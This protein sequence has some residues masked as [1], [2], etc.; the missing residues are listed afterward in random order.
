MIASRS[1]RMLLRLYPPD[2]RA[3]Y[4]EE[5]EALLADCAGRDGVWRPRL[6]LV[7][8]ALRERARAIGSAGR[9][10]SGDE[11]VRDATLLVLWAWILFV[12]AGLSVQKLSEQW[13]AATP[14]ATRTAPAVAF[15]VLV[16]TSVVG[17]VLVLAGIAVALPALVR[18]LRAGGWPSVRRRILAAAAMGAL[19]VLALS[20]LALWAQGLTSAQRNGGD[21]AYDLA[22]AATAVLIL[23]SLV[24]WGA[25]A[26]AV[27][28]RIELGSARLVLEARI[29]VAATASMAVMAGATIVWRGTLPTASPFVGVDIVLMLLATA[30]GTVGARRAI[31][32]R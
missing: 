30:L 1:T 16:A 18:S 15:D 28:R 19:T 8:G 27:A 7:A 22:F 4:G 20:A 31:A 32:V 14:P 23:A 17:S 13:R 25:A 5:L 21:L 3:R 12:A 6:D 2:W 11:R 10:G 9:R 29:S 24:S 26:T